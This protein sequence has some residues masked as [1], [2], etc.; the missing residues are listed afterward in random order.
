MKIQQNKIERALTTLLKMALHEEIAHDVEWDSL[1]DSDWKDCYMLAV[2]HGV[3]AVAFDGIELLPV[4][5]QPCRP[6]RL[7][8]ALAVKNYENRY[9]RYCKTA[10]E[11]S[12]FYAK[13]GI[14]MVQLKGVGLSSYYPVPSHREG[15]DVDIYTYSLDPSKMSDSDANKLANKLMEDRGIAVEYENEKH[16]NFYYN[17]IPIENHK[18]FLDLNVNKIARP[19]DSLLKKLL[20]P[21]KVCLCDCQYEICVPSVEF[22]VL[23][24]SC[25]AGRH[26]CEGLRLHHIFDWACMLKRYGLSISKEIMDDKLLRFIYSLTE[27]CNILF[28]TN[29]S[30]AGDASLSREVYGQIMHPKYERNCPTSKLAIFFYKIARVFYV[31]HM[32]SK[33]YDRSLWGILWYSFVFHLKNPKTIFSKR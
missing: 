24:L 20:D 9:E 5:W 6:I 23:F 11:L 33:V 2:K 31:H 22:N 3:M 13:H 10:A 25:H 7:S 32:Q 26:Y 27:I 28:E 12:S 21:H 19:M 17:G 14:A 18:T 1:S 16:S 8:W 4:E 15:G 30:F 29:V